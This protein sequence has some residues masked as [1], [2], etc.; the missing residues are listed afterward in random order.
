MKSEFKIVIGDWSGDGHSRFEEFAF[1]ANHSL[2]NIQ[3]AYR[4]SYK[5]V[6]LQFH[7]T[8]NDNDYTGQTLIKIPDGWEYSKCSDYNKQFG[9]LS[10]YEESK[11]SLDQAATLLSF[12]IPLT[13]EQFEDGLQPEELA[14]LILHFVKVSLPTLECREVAMTSSMKNTNCPAFNGWWGDLNVFMGY[15][16]F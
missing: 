9:L 4:K 8:Y 5:T 1:E 10:E 7:G 16:L 11:I 12:D 6:G 13:E 15:G 3:S 14:V 2:K